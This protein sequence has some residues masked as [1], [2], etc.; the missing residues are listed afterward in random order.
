MIHKKDSLEEIEEE[1]NQ[2]KIK[3]K[4]EVNK[5]KEEAKQK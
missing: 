1:K 4:E 5:A 2:A 3:L